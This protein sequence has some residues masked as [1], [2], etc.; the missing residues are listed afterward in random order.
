VEVA[1]VS[2]W[3][4]PTP[5]SVRAARGLVGDLPGAMST[6]L[7]ESVELVVSELA[8]NVRPTRP[9][10]IPSRPTGSVHDPDRGKGP[11]PCA[12]EAA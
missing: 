7:V 9:D 1:A 3:F 6:A 5:E 10:P 8:S 4:D 11:K 2:G 12:S